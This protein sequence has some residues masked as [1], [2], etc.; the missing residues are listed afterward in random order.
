M[1]SKG[2]DEDT[3]VS[4]SYAIASLIEGSNLKDDYIIP[5]F[6][7]PRILPIVTR[8]LKNAIKSQLK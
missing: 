3:L 2:L 7:D 4:A 6:N 8:I 5:K 1:R